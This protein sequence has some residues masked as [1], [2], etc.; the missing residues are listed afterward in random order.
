MQ[1][2]QLKERKADAVAIANCQNGKWEVH[3]QTNG[4]IL[5]TQRA[6]FWL[7]VIKLRE[8]SHTI[9]GLLQLNSHYNPIYNL[10]HQLLKVSCNMIS[11]ERDVNASGLL[12][13]SHSPALTGKLPPEDQ[14]RQR[15]HRWN[16]NVLAEDAPCSAFPCSPPLFRPTSPRDSV[17]VLR[18]TIR[19]KGKLWWCLDQAEKKWM[20]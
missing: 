4:D 17:P 12:P 15:N 10:Y 6:E 2:Y 8:S 9:I 7:T 16:A 13:S 18:A 19:T 5:S 3:L 11:P 1:S 14:T 20:L